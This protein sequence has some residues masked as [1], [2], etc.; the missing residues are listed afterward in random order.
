MRAQEIVEH[1]LD[2]VEDL[3]A[4][5][6]LLLQQ[7][8]EFTE[9]QIREMAQA[10][11]SPQADYITWLLRLRRRNAWDGATEPVRS[12]LTRFEEIKRARFNG[13]Q[14][15]RDINQFRSVEELGQTMEANQMAG[16]RKERKEKGAKQVS[17]AGDL[18]TF[19]MLTSDAA[20]KFA[21][22][23]GTPENPQTRWCTS[24]RATAQN[25]MDQGPLFVTMKG[26]DP[27]VQIH[28]ASNQAKNVSDVEINPAVAKEVAPAYADPEFDKFWSKFEYRPTGWSVNDGHIEKQLL[29][30]IK[31]W[32][33]EK[34]EGHTHPRT[35]E[36][37]GP[38]AKSTQEARESLRQK[39]KSFFDLFSTAIAKQDEQIIR[40]IGER[41]GNP[42]GL[43]AM[44]NAIYEMK[45]PQE[46]ALP[47]LLT[48]YA[49]FEQRFNE[50]AERHEHEN[51]RGRR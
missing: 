28:F 39:L 16:T 22:G 17:K 38:T 26:S 30:L 50:L 11:P 43:Q 19:Q 23:K 25:Y 36:W 14:G 34:L 4:K 13:Y 48:D 8:T 6:P 49:A 1:L 32:Y 44:F 9:E 40:Q 15:Q 21:I 10:D 31:R 3:N 45:H 35:G 33:N 47:P 5:M 24:A 51:Y 2:L 41:H 20:V 29:R 27:Y 12:Y 42:G 7:F 37:V 18:T 46:V